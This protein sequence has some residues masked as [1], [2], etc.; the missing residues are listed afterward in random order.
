MI[1]FF[2]N[3]RYDFLGQRKWA[4][5]ATA[6]F[7]VPGLLLLAVRVLKFCLDFTCVVL[8]LIDI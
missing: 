7:I 4:Y 3:A 2:A 6:L 1:R 5:L 8:L